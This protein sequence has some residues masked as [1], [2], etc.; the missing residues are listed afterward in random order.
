MGI[1][2]R[3]KNWLLLS[4]SD[5]KVLEIKEAMRI[6][7]LE[8]D[9]KVL[10]REAKRFDETSWEPNFWNFSG[11]NKALINDDLVDE[12][13]FYDLVQNS[14]MLDIKNQTYHACLE[15]YKKF[16]YGKGPGIRA[17]MP[18]IEVGKELSDAD[19]ILQRESN[20]YWRAFWIANGL[21]LKDKEISRRKN[22]DGDCFLCFEGENGKI[23]TKEVT[24]DGS[25]YIVPEFR[26]LDALRVKDWEGKVPFGIELE[27]NDPE[28]V[29][30]YHYSHP[31]GTGGRKIP[32]EFVIHWKCNADSD[33]R[34]G[35][36]ILTS[37]MHW[38]QELNRFAQNAVDRTSIQNAHVLIRTVKNGQSATEIHQQN[39]KDDNNDDNTIQR[40]VKGGTV[41]TKGAGVDYQFVGPQME[42]SRPEDARLLMLLIASGAG[43]AEYMVSADAS[44]ANYAST[45]VS[46]SPAVR[47]FEDIQDE[48]HF[49]WQLMWT[50]NT[51]FG[52]SSQQLKPN[53]P[54]Q[55]IVDWQPL[56]ARKIKDEA[57]AMAILEAMGLSAE[58]ILTKM[59]YNAKDEFARS[60]SEMAFRVDTSMDIAADKEQADSKDSLKKEVAEAVSE[61][62]KCGSSS[63]DH[64]AT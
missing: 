49:Y 61:S 22:R 16:V 5:R 27:D 32:A 31:D 1:L 20:D 2:K 47:T 59:G 64:E 36:P 56:I 21:G 34:R 63:C 4:S 39:L 55:C 48:D 50:L 62:I 8:L 7:V 54:S 38:F 58:T 25:T 29:K 37:C 12:G 46:E 41:I 52:V 51:A 44:N 10:D 14:R 11:A 23:A 30:F 19:K 9:M 17:E 28:K 3:A 60:R 40:R 33:W 15:T 53:A 42:G 35:L 26:F 45:M 57:E 18:E 13:D 43:L 6:K 24:V